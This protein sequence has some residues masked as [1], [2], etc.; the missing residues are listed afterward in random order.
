MLARTLRGYAATVALSASGFVGDSPLFALDYLLRLLRV[1]LLLAVWRQILGADAN[2]SGFTIGSVLTYTLIAEVF[3]EQLEV[4][5]QLIVSFWEG[6]F[7]GR[8]LQPLGLVGIF[9]AEMV[10]RWATS[11]AIFSV[12][13]LAI[14]PL[15]G[16]DPR[17]ASLSAGLLFV[18]SLLIAILVGLA[19]DFLF[20][21]ITVALEAPVWLIEYARGG[22]AAVL[23]G[24]LIPL[25]LLPWGLGAVFDYLPF[26]ST[27]SA[28]LRIY[29]GTGDALYLMAIQIG[30][31]VVLWPIVW[32]LWDA[33]REKMV[34]YGG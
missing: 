22:V 18:V 11:F 8:V 20:G 27:V 14:S 12:P 29:T 2:V 25:P 13:L 21:G 19:I 9:A 3:A 33:N 6:S 23:S 26:A 28:P 4:R 32:W 1:L 15:F 5:T 17:P 10:G 7:M 30:W 16:V 31:A 24:I 34:S